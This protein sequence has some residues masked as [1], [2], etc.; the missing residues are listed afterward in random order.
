MDGEVVDVP[1]DDVKLVRPSRTSRMPSGLMD[2]LTDREILEML[3]WILEEK[4]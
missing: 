3:A 2:G 1:V 4:R